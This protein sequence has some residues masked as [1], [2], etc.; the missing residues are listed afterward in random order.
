[1]CD[2]LQRVWAVFLSPCVPHN[3]PVADDQRKANYGEDR[4]VSLHK[5][6]G[7]AISD[8]INYTDINHHISQ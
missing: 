7:S 1:M 6:V 4:I 5:V 2:A 3:A 8:F